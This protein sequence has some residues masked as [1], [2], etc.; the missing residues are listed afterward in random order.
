MPEDNSQKTAITVAEKSYTIITENEGGENICIRTR[1]YEESMLLGERRS[2]FGSVGK[3][4]GSI[5]KIEDF[6]RHE[7]MMAV[8]VFKAERLREEGS[9]SHFLLE[10]KNLLRRR[11]V[12]PALKVLANALKHY[13][14]NPFLLTYYGCLVAVV[15]GEHER[16]VDTCKRALELLELKVPYEVEAHYPVFYLNLGR[17]YLAGGKKK[18]AVDC[19]I[20]GL[21]YDGR[22]EELVSEMKKVGIRKKPPIPFLKRGNPI[23]KYIGKLIHKL[24]T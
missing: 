14:D 18:D 16:G 24:K 11:N 20:K 13:P 4:I 7:H 3:G 15:N 6:I 5:K 2:Y 1:F 21:A 10:V 17:A 9:P 19:F 12:K 23:N 8:N 22:N